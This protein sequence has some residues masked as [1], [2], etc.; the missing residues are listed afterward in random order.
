MVMGYLVG[1]AGPGVAAMVLGAD[2]PLPDMS[3]VLADQPVEFGEVVLGMAFRPM[4]LQAGQCVP[5]HTH[6]HNHVT[7]VC[8]GR[9][10]LWVDGKYVNEFK[11]YALVPVQ[12]GKQHVW[13]AQE[14]NTR[15]VCTSIA[16][17]EKGD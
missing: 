1:G 3:N 9:A 6:G 11:G 12:A 13:Q 16:A 5:Q 15:L 7:Q 14:D 4:L 17:E 8:H 2:Y 10:R